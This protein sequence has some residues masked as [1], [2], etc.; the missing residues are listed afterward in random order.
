MFHFQNGKWPSWVKKWDDPPSRLS[1]VTN[2][3]A[4]F[5]AFS[6]SASWETLFHGRYGFGVVGW[7]LSFRE[8]WDF[9]PWKTATLREREREHWERRVDREVAHPHPRYLKLQKK[10]RIVGFFA[11]VK[12]ASSPIYP[13]TQEE[14]NRE[15]IV[16]NSFRNQLILTH[17][18][19]VFPTHFSTWHPSSPLTSSCSAMRRS[20]SKTPLTKFLATNDVACPTLR[21][22]WNEQWAFHPYETLTMKSSLVNGGSLFHG[23]IIISITGVFQW[24]IPM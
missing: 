9:F 11:L 2:S 7:S 17:F 24:K 19:V 20:R 18:T 16:Y 3:M 1:E 8:R 10:L 15:V 23:P 6:F 4:F 22:C 21:W 13:N 12:S 5:F 14:K